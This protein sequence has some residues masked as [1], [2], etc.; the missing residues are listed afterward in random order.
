MNNSTAAT[1]VAPQAPVMVVR[2]GQSIQALDLARVQAIIGGTRVLRA[3]DNGKY[4][5]GIKVIGNGNFNPSTVQPSGKLSPASFIYNVNLVSEVAMSGNK[6]QAAVAALNAAGDDVEL[7]H[8]AC[9]D[10]LN[11]LRVS[12]NTPKQ[13]F[14]N[15]QLIKGTITVVTTEKGSL[16]KMENVTAMPAENAS[17]LSKGL[18]LAGI[19]STVA[20]ASSTI[21]SSPFATAQPTD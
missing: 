15:G 4:I 7:V 9:N 21:A 11:A 2:N 8:D 17:T 12:F 1:A 13:S 20:A 6:Y 19:D 18:V 5:D 3:S 10:I 16:I 14:S